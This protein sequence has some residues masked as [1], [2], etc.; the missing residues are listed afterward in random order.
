MRPGDRDLPAYIVQQPLNDDTLKLMWDDLD[1]C[2]AHAVTYYKHNLLTLDQAK[3]YAMDAISQRPVYLISL[4]S[5]GIL[6]LEE[7][8]EYLLEIEKDDYD[9]IAI[10]LYKLGVITLDQLKARVKAIFYKYLDQRDELLNLGLIEET[11][12]LPNPF[13]GDSDAWL[14]TKATD[15]RI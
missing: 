15:I 13:N 3:H 4:F 1:I 9:Y 5:G 10:R 7:I 2:P 12:L 11:H 8:K 6:T 14:Q